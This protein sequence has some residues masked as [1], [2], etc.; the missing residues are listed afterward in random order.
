MQ[1]DALSRAGS[2]NGARKIAIISARK[3][4]TKTEAD[5]SD[6]DFERNV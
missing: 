4:C 5:F 2:I 1:D 6:L 3:F